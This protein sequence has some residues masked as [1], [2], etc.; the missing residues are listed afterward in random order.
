MKTLVIL[1]LSIAFLWSDTPVF[2]CD[3]DN[4]P[5]GTYTPTQMKAAWNNPSWENGLTEGRGE[6][7]QEDGKTCL[8]IL[9]PQGLLSNGGTQWEMDLGQSYDT[10]WVSYNLKF[11]DSFNF[12]KGGK[13]PGLGGGSTPTGGQPVTGE[14][15]FSAR[16]MWKYTATASDS[17]GVATQY[18]YHMDQPSTYGEYFYYAYPNPNWSSARRYFKPGQWHSVKTRIIINTPGQFDGRITSWLDDELAMDS[19]AMRFRAD[20]IT[21][22]GVDKFL[23]STF[24]GGGDVSWAASKDEHIYFDDFV[25]SKTDTDQSTAITIPYRAN[26]KITVSSSTQIAVISNELRFTNLAPYTVNIFSA[27]GQQLKEISGVETSVPLN[28]LGLAN[29]IYQMRVVQGVDLFTGQFILK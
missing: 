7:V 15:G 12:V 22:F 10:L 4:E 1:L 17:Q 28:S 25:I 26:Q 9:Y 27:N 5:I 11:Q 2:M 14:D 24:F 3:F 16:I 13:L 23:F 21:H 18:I 19:S 20:G 8:R 6:I 29:G